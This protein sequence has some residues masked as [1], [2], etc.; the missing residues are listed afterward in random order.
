MLLYHCRTIV[1]VVV[2]ANEVAATTAVAVC[3]S[4]R[5]YYCYWCA[6]YCSDR[7]SNADNQTSAYELKQY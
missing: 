5:S 4:L 1:V 3:A 7:L 6:G 2:P